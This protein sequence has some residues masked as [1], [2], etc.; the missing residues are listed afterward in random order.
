M[1]T[2]TKAAIK[3]AYE[4]E[5]IMT[6]PSSDFMGSKAWRDDPES[7]LIQCV[8]SL[9]N[10]SNFLQMTNVKSII[11]NCLYEEFAGKE[12]STLNPEG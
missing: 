12:Y 8:R 7:L 1:K 3:K 10:E 4:S 2:I 9:I 5:E 11:L 6:Y